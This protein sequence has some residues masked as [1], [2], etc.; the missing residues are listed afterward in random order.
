MLG[1]NVGPQRLTDSYVKHKRY[2]CQVA[3][4]APA[5]QQA[6]ADPVAGSSCPAA[7]CCAC[8]CTFRCSGTQQRLPLPAGWQRAIR[9]ASWGPNVHVILADM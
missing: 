7:S 6:A 5:S 9:A 3:D 2:S 8:R 1:S 4:G